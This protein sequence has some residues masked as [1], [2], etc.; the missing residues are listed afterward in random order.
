M[1]FRG[2]CPAGSRWGEGRRRREREGWCGRQC[3]LSNLAENCEARSRMMVSHR[4]VW[5]CISAW[6][7]LLFE[8]GSAST[9]SEHRSPRPSLN[10]DPLS[11]TPP[12]D[13]A[14]HLRRAMYRPKPILRSLPPR[15]LHLTGRTRNPRREL[16]AEDVRRFDASA[17]RVGRHAAAAVQVVPQAAAYAGDFC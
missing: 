6:M 4:S 17:V 3:H 9:R 10:H 16:P 1:C 12:P 15:A 2:R 5:G 13:P 14:P 7:S 11:Y 8:N